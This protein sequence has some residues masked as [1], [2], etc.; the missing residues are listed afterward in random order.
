MFSRETQAALLELN[1]SILLELD[2]ERRIREINAHGSDVLGAPAEKIRGRDWLE[3]FDAESE[4]DRAFR[5]LTSALATGGSRDRELDVVDFAG[6]RRRIHWRCLARRRPDGSPDGWLCT[7]LDVTDRAQREQHAHLAQDRLTRVARLAT[8]GEMAAGIAHEINQPLTAITTYARACERYLENGQPDYDD[9]REALR[10]IGAEGLRA[11]G[12]V[13]KLRQMVR[14]DSPEQRE[15]LDVNRMIEDIRSLLESDARLHGVDL[16][17]RLTPGLPPVMGQ[18]VQ[19]QQVVLNLARN[20]FEALA[21]EPSSRRQ[22]TIGSAGTSE[23]VEISVTDNG[24]GIAPQIADRLFDPFATT[25]GNGT[26]LGLPISRTIV[27]SHGG[28]IT[29]GAAEPRGCVFSVRLPED[30]TR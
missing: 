26:G 19:L 16:R 12:I 11:G 29:V 7:G 17:F 28:T 8:L 15:R 25:K 22:V 6:N 2:R 1:Q 13:H 4:R 23:G 30:V 18:A 5:L 10:E 21:E 27:S 14:T 3:L 24:P 20:A 9:L